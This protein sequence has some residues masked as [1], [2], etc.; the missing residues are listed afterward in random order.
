LLQSTLVQEIQKHSDEMQAVSPHGQVSALH[1]P[2][3]LLHG[4]TDTV[5]PA[6]ET[7]WL[8]KDVPPQELK[9]VLVSPAMNMIHVD[10]QHPVT[11]SEKWA[12]VD[13]M[14]QVLGAS[15]RVGRARH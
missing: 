14:A 9:A 2:V 1:V 10:G 5:I 6:S 11:N 13:F 4:T 8:A 15:D 12:L 7:L 3:Y